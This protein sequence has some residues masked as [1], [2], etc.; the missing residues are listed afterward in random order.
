MSN[1]H[2][3]MPDNGLSNTLELSQMNSLIDDHKQT[4]STVINENNHTTLKRDH[5]SSRIVYL[6]SIIGFV[7]D[8]GNVW[9][10]PTT[11][12]R[13]GGGAFLIPYFTFLFLVGLPCMYM[14]LAIGQYHRLGY[15]T[16]WN[17]VCPMLKGIGYSITVPWTSCNNT[18]NTPNCYSISQSD[19]ISINNQSCSSANEYYE[20]RML[21]S[22]KSTGINDLGSLR[23]G[24]V[25]CSMIVFTLIYGSIYKGVK[26]AGK[27]IWFTALIPYVVLIILLFRSFT[28]EGI[29][30]GLK[31]YISPTFDKLK[32]YSVWQAAA[33]Q[34]FF[35]LGPGFGVL[36]G[37][38]SYSD[39]HDNVPRTAVAASLINC[40]TSLLYGIVV[41]SGIGY[42]SNRLK[43]DVRKFAE[44]QMG[45]VFVVY[46]ELLASIKGA[47]FFSV[48]FFVMLITLGL[49]SVFG[50]VECIYTAISDEFSIFRSKPRLSRAGVVLVSFIASIPTLTHGGKNVVHFMDFF[51]TSPAI[52]LV[53]LLELIAVCW[54]YGIKQFSLN[55]EE[56]TGK[57]PSI[58][59][60]ITCCFIA[61]MVLCVLY[62]CS[63]LQF[64][65]QEFTSFGDKKTVIRLSIVGWSISTFSTL[66]IPVYALWWAVSK[67]WKTCSSSTLENDSSLPLKSNSLLEINT[68]SSKEE[69]QI[70]PSAVEKQPFI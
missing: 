32:E 55:V 15:I 35:S 41:F 57:K 66:P 48:L 42:L 28:L 3:T 26:T 16:V 59:W 61:P 58:Y 30:D 23:W 39:F 45:L 19:S 14:E 7:V 31:Y 20:R 29:M 34:I 64:N 44:S 17:K 11:C 33:V 22:Q 47:P 36:L 49:D 6:L 51:G 53:V 62:V 25:G 67:R 13:N 2:L 56:M 54:L 43:T 10:F 52:M 37:Y 60:R 40:F 70:R 63:F 27:A 38:A 5:W 69:G 1:E 8:L 68:T 9:R 24:L 21:Q 12:Y 4:V 18:W 46:P 65:T 50:G